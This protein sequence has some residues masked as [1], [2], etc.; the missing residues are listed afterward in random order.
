MGASLV[1]RMWDDSSDQTHLLWAIA[2]A[3]VVLAQP[4]SHEAGWASSY[5][6]GVDKGVKELTTCDYLTR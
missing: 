2:L 6:K 5:P 1:A 3:K 4:D